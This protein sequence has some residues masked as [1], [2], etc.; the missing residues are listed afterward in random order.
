MACKTREDSQ[1]SRY[2]R[3]GL[4]KEHCWSV[5]DS[6]VNLQ[7]Q[8]QQS[9]RQSLT[10]N[11]DCQWPSMTFPPIAN[12]KNSNTNRIWGY[13]AFN[14]KSECPFSFSSFQVLLA[15]KTISKIDI[16]IIV[17][18]KNT[19]RPCG[20]KFKLNVLEDAETIVRIHVFQKPNLLS[21]LLPF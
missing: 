4:E 9:D 2:L 15:F 5:N 11:V 10:V 3:I 14:G 20:F 18:N 8:S 17:S 19:F 6:V 7:S 21:F 13:L 12:A 1:A 16:N